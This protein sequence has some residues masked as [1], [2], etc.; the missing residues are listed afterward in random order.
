[1]RKSIRPSRTGCDHLTVGLIK[2][3][4]TEFYGRSN[5]KKTF[6]CRLKFRRVEKE[7][8]FSIILLTTGTGEVK[9]RNL[10]LGTVDRDRETRLETSKQTFGLYSAPND[11]IPPCNAFRCLKYHILYAYYIIQS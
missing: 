10:S 2:K 9:K 5:R 7:Q 6:K 8:L 3:I 11:I 4:F 1:M